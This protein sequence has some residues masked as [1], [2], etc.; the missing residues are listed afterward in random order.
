MKHIDRELR[1]IL[2]AISLVFVIVCVVFYPPLAGAQDGGGESGGQTYYGQSS[3]Y[4]E[5]ERLASRME[6]FMKLHKESVRNQMLIQSLLGQL[7][8][9]EIKNAKN[10]R[11]AHISDSTYFDTRTG[12]IFKRPQP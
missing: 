8:E 10:G 11:F 4:M 5:V 12:E 7:I 2:A 6:R 9:L 3:G 1:N